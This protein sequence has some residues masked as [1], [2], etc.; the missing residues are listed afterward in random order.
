M[1]ARKR[2]LAIAAKVSFAMGGTVSKR[3]QDY[4]DGRGMPAGGPRARSAGGSKRR[5]PIKGRRP[6][7]KLYGNSAK[8]IIAR[9]QKPQLPPLQVPGDGG[10]AGTANVKLDGH[11]A[12]VPSVSGTL[13]PLRM[14]SSPR[15]AGDAALLSPRSLGSPRASSRASTSRSLKMLDAFVPRPTPQILAASNWGD[16]RRL[17]AGLDHSKKQVHNTGSARCERCHTGW[18]ACA[19]GCH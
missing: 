6:N 5:S 7:R 12:M 10:T 8:A 13:P 11:G 19:L 1:K 2:T 4:A 16:R 18:C 15:N 17:S 14:R 9:A 3:T